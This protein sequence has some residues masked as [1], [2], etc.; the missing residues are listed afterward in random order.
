MGSS[1]KLLEDFVAWLDDNADDLRE[2]QI[3]LYLFNNG[4]LYDYL[5]S[6]RF[7]DVRITIYSIPL[8]GYD[9]RSPAQIE[10]RKTGECL[11]RYSKYDVAASL[12]NRMLSAPKNIEMRLVPH[13]Y[14]RSSRVRS[15]S[16]GQMPYSLHCKSFFATLSN[17]D[18]YVGLSSTN[19]A[20]RDAGKMEIVGVV[21]LNDRMKAS[22]KDFYQGL[23]ENSCKIQDFDSE[24]DW[25]SFQIQS[26][27]RPEKSQLMF[28]APFYKDSSSDFEENL[29][30]MIKKAKRRIIICAQ[31]VSSY[32]YSYER[33]Y[34][35]ENATPGSVKKDGF[36]K[37][38]LKKSEEGVK[39]LILSQ[40]YVDSFG[41]HGCR[42]P[43][44]TRSFIQFAEAAK[45][46]GCH[47]YVNDSIHCKFALIDDI[48]LVTTCNL[49]PTQFIYLPNVRIN[50]FEN[51]PGASYS[52]IF[53]EMGA[54]Y[55]A[56]DKDMV[57]ALEGV[58]QEIVHDSQSRRMF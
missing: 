19:F 14:L 4:R 27:K 1:P 56:W 58:T 39:T 41:N 48:A 28:V 43:Q 34:T 50:V 15:F 55:A 54:Y 30:T 38:V 49:T 51:I 57:K 36:L 53:C 31:H 37:D 45:R 22:A 8:E 52:G 23:H 21:A 24:K 12:Y 7:A 9:P 18:S 16:R 26:R 33:L 20:V 2:L 10:N 29:K 17:G 42:K 40:T 6:E 13:M 35:S 5:C 44:N 46:A 3:A 32:E 25:S 11:G 47:Y